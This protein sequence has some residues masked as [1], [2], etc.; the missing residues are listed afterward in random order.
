M[1]L[2]NA[3]FQ[4]T[5]TYS[6]GAVKIYLNGSYRNNGPTIVSADTTSNLLL[7]AG[8]SFSNIKVYDFMKYNRQLSNQEILQNYQAMLPRFLNKNIVT[9]GLIEYLDAGYL[10]SYPTSGNT[11]YNVAGVSGGTGT[12]TNGPTYDSGN[13]GSIV[14]DGVDDYLSLNSVT[15]NTS[16]FTIDMWIY[17]SSPQPVY[18]N[19][20]VYWYYDNN[21][22]IGIFGSGGTGFQFKD[23]GIAGNPTLQVSNC[24]NKWINITLG[25]ANFTPFMYNNGVSVGTTTNFRN[26]DINLINLFRSQLLTGRNMV[27]KQAILGIYNRAL[28]QDEITQNYNAQ[29]SRFGL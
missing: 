19:N 12:L 13:G 3:P 23:N 2:M 26:M 6:G 27:G 7:A 20:W 4:Y 29:K 10:G 9:N 16:G 17:M 22:E 14:F 5:V 24:T 25:C 21:V 28:T 15:V 11:W 8:D 1:A 18:V